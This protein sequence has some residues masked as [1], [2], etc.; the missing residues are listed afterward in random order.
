MSDAGFEAKHAE[1]RQDSIRKSHLQK[2]AQ[3][4]ENTFLAGDSRTFA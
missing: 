2:A 4:D 1:Y 3:I